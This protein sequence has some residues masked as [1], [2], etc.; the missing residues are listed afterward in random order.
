MAKSRPAGAARDGRHAEAAR[1]IRTHAACTHTIEGAREHASPPPRTRIHAQPV[2]A[3]PAFM[4]SPP[5]RLAGSDAAFLPS[6]SSSSS[7]F[8]ALSLSS[9]SSSPPSP[10]SS[11]SLAPAQVGGLRWASVHR[12]SVGRSVGRRGGRSF[13]HLGLPAAGDK[14]AYVSAP[15]LGSAPRAARGCAATPRRSNATPPDDGSRRCNACPLLPSRS[16]W[17]GRRL[18]APGHG[19]Q[20]SGL[21]MGR[22]RKCAHVTAFGHCCPPVG[23]CRKKHRHRLSCSA[24]RGHPIPSPTC[25]ISTQAWR[26]MLRFRSKEST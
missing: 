21:T 20:S 15:R 14:P 18:T 10:S 9:Y 25:M 6:F 17:S 1:R 7:S 8:C 16:G 2:H 3:Q 26:T 19:R 4:R 13:R 23:S 24:S 5:P 12:L 11:S 22:T